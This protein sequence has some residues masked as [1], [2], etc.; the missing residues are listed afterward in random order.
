MYWGFLA[1]PTSTTHRRVRRSSKKYK[2]SSTE[3]ILAMFWTRAP[4][5][6][7]DFFELTEENRCQD[8]WLSVFLKR[9][10]HGNMDYE[11][12]CF[13]HGLPTKHAGSWMPDTDAVQCANASCQGLAVAWQK[14]VLSEKKRAW[15]ERRSDEWAICQEN[16]L[17]RCRVRQ[18][19]T[20]HGV[21]DAKFADAPLIH[22][23]NAPSTTP[24]WC[25]PGPT[26]DAQS[27]SCYG[28]LQRTRQPAA[29]IGIQMKTNSMPSGENGPCTMIR[30]PP[31]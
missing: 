9:A 4:D 26:L 12:H 24:R 28:L 31:A 10:R 19:T 30:N 8:K 18:S 11:L 25:A 13:M 14:E 5:A 22:P 20:E 17:K 15:E 16:S 23:W 21:L 27:K 7:Q 6:I 29:S 1:I 3:R 2:W